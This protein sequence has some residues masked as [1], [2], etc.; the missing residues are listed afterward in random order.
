MTDSLSTHKNKATNTNLCDL[1]SSRFAPIQDTLMALLDTADI[2]NLQQT[3]KT[4][5][6]E[7]ATK[8]QAEDYN[9]NIKLSRWFKRPS[10]FRSTQATCGALIFCPFA[11]HF[12]TC[13]TNPH[14]ILYLAR[15]TRLSTMNAF[16]LA[17]D[18][19]PTSE[20]VSKLRSNEHGQTT[21]VLKLWTKVHSNGTTT[22]VMVV[23]DTDTSD[24][25]IPASKV[26]LQLALTTSDLCFIS[27][28]KA[29]SL[30]P[31]SIFLAKE[32]YSLLRIVSNLSETLNS[33]AADEIRVK[34]IHWSAKHDDANVP[35]NLTRYR[36]VGDTFTWSIQ[37][38]VEEIKIP[39]HVPDSVLESHTFRLALPFGL[40]HM[41]VSHYTLMAASI[42][43]PVLKYAHLV[44]EHHHHREDKDYVSTGYAV[45]IARLREKLDDVLMLEMTK[46][47]EEDRPREYGDVV[48]RGTHRGRVDWEGVGIE[49]PASWKWYDGDVVKALEKAWRGL[50]EGDHGKERKGS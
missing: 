31:R 42:T 10:A 46:M 36:R 11:L 40:D 44:A 35:Q 13:S 18:Y 50:G 9:I 1:L 28:N 2:I 19:T 4:L 3:S 20:D 5:Y 24:A 47:G 33:L 16:L 43:H 29:Y 15:E 21:F 34:G 17:D 12:F 49:K 22:H 23:L 37:L 25:T 39:S 45:Q 6:V 27:W 8:L 38:D 32:A 48:V 30:H 41:P 14:D 26:A 7:I